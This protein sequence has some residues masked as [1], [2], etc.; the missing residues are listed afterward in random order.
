MQVVINFH[1]FSLIRESGFG[2]FTSYL[3]LFIS[4]NGGFGGLPTKADVSCLLPTLLLSQ[5]VYQE[6]KTGCGDS[7]SGL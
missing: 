1:P 3:Y 5:P 7:D 4:T 2:L 6:Y